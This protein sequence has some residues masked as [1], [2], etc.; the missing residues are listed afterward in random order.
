M[1]E[2]ERSDQEFLDALCEIGTKC[3]AE[4]INEHPDEPRGGGMIVWAER[5]FPVPERFKFKV[6]PRNTMEMILTDTKTGK[7]T[8]IPVSGYANYRKLL[9]DLFSEEQSLFIQKEFVTNAGQK[10][11]YKIECDALTE[12]DFETAAYL[13]NRYCVRK[14]IRFCR[15]EGVPRGGLRLSKPLEK[16]IDPDGEYVLVVD[17]VFTTGGSIKRHIKEIDIPEEKEILSFVV[18]ARN[19]NEVPEWIKP[20]FTMTLKQE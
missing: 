3:I 7:K 9:N 1:T 14:S 20:V 19:E 13:I 18:F 16:Y 10:A 8:T 2:E 17:D 6:S 5:C 15:V 12:E 11:Q 4:R